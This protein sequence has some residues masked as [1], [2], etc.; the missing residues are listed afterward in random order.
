MI[1]NISNPDLVTKLPIL[2]DLCLISWPPQVDT[3]S[4][5][6]LHILITKHKLETMIKV[7]VFLPLEL[8][9]SQ[10]N[11]EITLASANSL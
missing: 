2:M 6:I 7:I 5:Q 3:T 4:K 10:F 9:A 1:S 11:S 8:I